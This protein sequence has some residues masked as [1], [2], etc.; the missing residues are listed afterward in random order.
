MSKKLSDSVLAIIVPAYNEEEI[1]ND[2][3]SKL[4]ELLNNLIKEKLVSTESFICFI[5][6]G[7]KDKTWEMIETLNQVNPQ[8]F[9]GIKLAR[10]FGHQFALI[11]GLTENEADIFVSIDA[12]LQ[13]DENVIREMILRY[14]EGSDIVYGVRDKRDHDSFFKKISALCFYKLMSLM[15]VQTVYNHADF[16]LLSARAVKAL[17]G[18]TETNLFLRG[19]MPLLG[20]E[21]SSVYYDRKP[22][23]AGETKYPLRKMLTF[24]WEGITSFSVK[25]LKIATIVGFLMCVFSMGFLIYSLIQHYYGHTEIGWTSLI[26]SIYFL[27]G[28]QLFC[29]GII[30]EYLGKVYKE[31]KHRPRYIVEKRL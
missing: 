9:K 10:N 11:A 21:T 17:N 19:L 2:S 27:G 18:F 20:F 31:V 24:A 6:D 15:G 29:I 28:V 1:L 7:S 26:F 3:A 12:D 14:N 8:R 5:N 16:R 13:D 25:P 22:R 4:Q 23:L 30:G